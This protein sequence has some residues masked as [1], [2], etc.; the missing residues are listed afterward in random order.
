MSEEMKNPTPEQPVTPEPKSVPQPEVSQ[1]VVASPVPGPAA[2]ATTSEVVPAPQ[3]APAVPTPQPSSKV[4]QQPTPT[5]V[6]APMP[7]APQQPMPQ[8]LVPQQPAPAQQPIFPQQAPAPVQPPVAPQPSVPQQPHAQQPV[9]PQQP[10]APQ[11]GQPQVQYGPAPYPYGM[12]PI[13]RKQNVCAIIGLCLGVASVFFNMFF[14]APSIAGIV[15]S[16]IGLHQYKKDNAVNPALASGKG[17]AIAGL[18][19]SIATLLIYAAYFIFFGWLIAQS[20]GQSVHYST[21]IG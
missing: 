13:Q 5:H 3:P 18:I 7:A 20:G 16:I 9:A 10:Y 11:P 6:P 15:T 19:V 4:V 8:Q 21:H 14:C 17:L 2:Q 12:P 1:P